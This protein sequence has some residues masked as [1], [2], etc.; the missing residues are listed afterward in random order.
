MIRYL[1]A[2]FGYGVAL[3]AFFRLRGRMA[4]PLLV[5]AGAAAGLLAAFLPG[6]LFFLVAEGPSS[7]PLLL[8]LGVFLYVPVMLPVLVLLL[9]L[10][11]LLP[12]SSPR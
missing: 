2:L 9:L 11:L 1:P 6:A 10:G 5:L 8:P 4:L 3:L 7:L 12:P